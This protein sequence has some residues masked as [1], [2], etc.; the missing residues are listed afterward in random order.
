MLAVEVDGEDFQGG[1]ICKL[2]TVTRLSD[3]DVV[4]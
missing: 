2:M 3:G 1:D 4:T